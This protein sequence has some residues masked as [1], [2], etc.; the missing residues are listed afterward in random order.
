M[1]WVVWVPALASAGECE[2][3]FSECK[4][5]CSIQ[6]GGSIRD[7]MKD[8]FVRC[9]RKCTTTSANCHERTN[10]TKVNHLNEGALDKSPSSR[11]VDENGMPI[12]RKRASTPAAKPPP[13]SEPPR[14]SSPKPAD[15]PPL[16]PKPKAEPAPP[17]RPEPREEPPKRVEP[18]KDDDDLRNY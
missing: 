3:D 8:K 9:L 5:L 13:K 4:E 18:K 1:L 6:Y 2:D 11:D 12:L 16:E 7:E 10:E 17:K 14:P 15:P